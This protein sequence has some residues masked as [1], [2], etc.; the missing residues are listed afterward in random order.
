MRR[1]GVRAMTLAVALAGLAGATAVAPRH[2]DCADV[3]ADAFVHQRRPDLETAP[4]AVL[5]G[6]LVIVRDTGL[7]S[8]AWACL[9]TGEQDEL[10]AAGIRND[11]SLSA[12]VQS[13]RHDYTKADRLGSLP[14]TNGTYIYVYRLSRPWRTHDLVSPTGPREWF[15]RHVLRQPVGPQLQEISRTESILLLVRV[16][17]LGKVDRFGFEGDATDS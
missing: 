5:H 3:V 9:A 4:A 12:T 13:T 16:D 11:A 7:G 10:S 6:R 8:G 17:K 2:H 15:L 14:Q 1:P